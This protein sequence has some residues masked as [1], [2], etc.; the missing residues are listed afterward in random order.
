[1]KELV[2]HVDVDAGIVMVGDPCYTIGQDASSAIPTWSDMCDKLFNPGNEVVT[3]SGVRHVV[4]PFRDGHEGA[5]IVVPAGLGDGTYPV[6]IE[7][8]DMGTWG[9]R[10]KSLTVVFIDDDES[11]G[12]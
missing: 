7:T 1:M 3:E 4:K 6:Y 12:A 8:V 9:K 5:G 2:G 10:V 11:E